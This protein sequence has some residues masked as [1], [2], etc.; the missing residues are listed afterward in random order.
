MFFRYE[1]PSP[2]SFDYPSHEQGIHSGNAG[3]IGSVLHL[4]KM[5]F[6]LSMIKYP[7]LLSSSITKWSIVLFSELHF[8]TFCFMK[9]NFVIQEQGILIP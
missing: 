6:N 2:S 4:M 8:I 5:L 3:I 1:D 9:L 7:S